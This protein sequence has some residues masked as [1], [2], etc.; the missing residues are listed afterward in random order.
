MRA[1]H[2]LGAL[3]STYDIHLAVGSPLFPLSSAELAQAQLPVASRLL[4]PLGPMHA[5]KLFACR[6]L[7][8]CLPGLRSHRPLEWSNKSRS[9][10]QALRR[11]LRKK[12]VSLIHAF[13]LYMY[14]LVELIH[15]WLPGILAQLDL[16]DVESDTRLSLAELHRRSGN[17][18]AAAAASRDAAFYT[19]METQL[20]AHLGRIWVCSKLDHVRLASRLG[21]ANLAVVPNVVSVPAEIPPLPTG[22]PFTFLFV[23]SLGYPPN[24]AAADWFTR[25]VL[26][27]L[28]RS[29]PIPVRFLIVGHRPAGYTLPSRMEN[30]TVEL[31]GFAASLAQHYSAASAAVVPVTAGGGTRVKLLEAFSFRRPVVTT[32]TGAEGLNL[33]GEVHALVAN[34]APTFIQHCRRL[35]NDRGLSDR[36]T[37]QAWQLLN[38]QYGLEAMR[39]AIQCNALTKAKA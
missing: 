13:R 3:A 7:Q 17:W 19:A 21:L 10:Q 32:S 30:A 6:L 29:S 35:I 38:E 33:Q 39:S 24:A 12:P 15:T 20:L 4:L 14:P 31:V 8:R 16:D 37:D 11:F 34:D 22:N 9:M 1:W 18:T 23:G 5:P 2:S 36:L 27:D 28:A 26:P 25:C